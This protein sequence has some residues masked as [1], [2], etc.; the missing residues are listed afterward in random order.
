MDFFHRNP[1][2]CYIFRII[3]T[4]GNQILPPIR[5][6]RN[7][8]NVLQVSS[9]RR[10][11]YWWTFPIATPT[12]VIY[13]ESLQKRKLTID[14]SILQSD[15]YNCPS[16][17]VCLFVYVFVCTENYF[18]SLVQSPSSFQSHSLVLSHILVQRWPSGSS[19]SSRSPWSYIWQFN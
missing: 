1:Y 19:R 6:I 17:S 12:Y 5:K 14:P 9:S 10:Q 8:R 7:V 11:E 15:H 4:K 16:M 18:S 13:L 2:I 3:E